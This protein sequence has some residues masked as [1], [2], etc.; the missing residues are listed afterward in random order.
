MTDDIVGNYHAMRTMLRS[1][2]SQTAFQDAWTKYFKTGLSVII[3]LYLRTYAEL[4]NDVQA[5]H[6]HELDCLIKEN[7]TP[8]F[9]WWIFGTVH[10]YEC[11]LCKRSTTEK[12]GVS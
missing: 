4:D 1:A 12:H 11:E 2:S 7:K 6:N 5:L 8:D 3:P 9:V 10:E